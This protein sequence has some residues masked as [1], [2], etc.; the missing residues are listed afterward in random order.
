MHL[1]SLILLL[2]LSTLTTAICAIMTAAFEKFDWPPGERDDWSF[3]QATDPVCH[4][5]L[6]G[7]GGR[8]YDDGRN[9][10]YRR[11]CHSV[12]AG[13]ESGDSLTDIHWDKRSDDDCSLATCMYCHSAMRDGDA[14]SRRMPAC[15]LQ[16]QK[17]CTPNAESTSTVL[18][19]VHVASEFLSTFLQ[20]ALHIA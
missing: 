2:S 6:K 17:D 14:N 11:V 3:Y 1:P 13:D 9:G 8:V 5:I 20:S 15:A 4:D 18:D 10:V 12:T 19:R 7:T 16:D